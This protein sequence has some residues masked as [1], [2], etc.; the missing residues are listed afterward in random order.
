MPWQFSSLGVDC[1]GKASALSVSKVATG[2][3]S[4]TGVGTLG[5]VRFMLGLL[6]LMFLAVP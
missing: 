1:S 2:Y 4:T 6:C 3:S 5:F